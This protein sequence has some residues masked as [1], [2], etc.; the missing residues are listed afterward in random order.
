MQPYR[1]ACEKVRAHTERPEPDVPLFGP[2]Y[3]AAIM[4]GNF[5]FKI[6]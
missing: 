1:L 4:K 5:E 6:L 2:L 3:M